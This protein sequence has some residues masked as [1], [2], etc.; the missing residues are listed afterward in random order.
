M[1][2]MHSMTEKYM[3]PSELKV[4]SGLREMESFCSANGI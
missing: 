2:R 4:Y 3:K 1:V